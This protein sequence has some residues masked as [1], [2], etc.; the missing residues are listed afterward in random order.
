MSHHYSGPNFAFPHW[1]ARH[2]GANWP[3]WY[4][5]CMVREQP[6]QECHNERL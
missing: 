5:D 1:N 6:G 2:T 3:D 4:A